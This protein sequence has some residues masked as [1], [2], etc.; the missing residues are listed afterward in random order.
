[1]TTVDLEANCTCGHIYDEHRIDHRGYAHEC[2][3]EDC[4]CAHF[5][6]DE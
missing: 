4:D 2:E 6:E 3:V 5:E 1:M